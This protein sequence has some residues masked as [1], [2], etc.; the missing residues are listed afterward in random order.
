MTSEEATASPRASR[1]PLTSETTE[2]AKAI[3]PTPTPPPHAAVEPYAV[4]PYDPDE[5]P[6]VPLPVAVPVTVPVAVPLPA[7]DARTGPGAA[8]PDEYRPANGRHRGRRRAGRAERRSAT[9]EN[10]RRRPDEGPAK[11]S[12][13]RPEKPEKQPREK[14]AARGTREP[15]RGAAARAG[16][17]GGGAVR[18]PKTQKAKTP[19]RTGL[20]GASAA[21]AI[22]A[23]AM[24]SGLLPGNPLTVGDSSGGGRGGVPGGQVRADAPIEVPPGARPGQPPAAGHTG[25]TVPVARPGT[26]VGTA[27]DRG[28][29]RSLVQAVARTSAERPSAVADTTTASTAA[30]TTA[31]AA[32]ASVT[33]PGSAAA[34]VAVD[35]RRRDG[36]PVASG[37]VEQAAAARLRADHAA[38][39]GTRAAAEAV[40]DSR[41]AAARTVVALVNAERAKA[42]CRPLRAEARLTS[43][44]QSM[45]EDMARRGFFDHTDPDG[46]SPWDR[47]ARHGVRNLGGENIARGHADAHAVVDAWMR[48][49]GHRQNILNCDYRTLGVGVEHGAGG[50][51]WTQDFGY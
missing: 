38:E 50:P 7:G 1:D 2:P 30:S 42:G 43:L 35:A 10:G 33:V 23:V 4:E 20:L 26:A 28:S 18:P 40:A 34:R 41:G 12:A 36:V 51:W 8:T 16:A 32:S 9:P 49:A 37:R 45:S 11:A 15:G 31:S 5:A 21:V 47:A 17:V 3:T 13:P 6:T 39:A 22:G 27:Y 14:K 46:R 24:V 29:A 19:A 44:A 48:S 25:P